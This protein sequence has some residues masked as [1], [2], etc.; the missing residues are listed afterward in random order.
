MSTK[1]T[2]TKTAAITSLTDL[3]VSP[4]NDLRKDPLVKSRAPSPIGQESSLQ[5]Y[6][7]TPI[8]QWFVSR[9]GVIGWQPYGEMFVL[10]SD[11][12]EH[13]AGNE[14]YLKGLQ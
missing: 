6:D 4:R 9:P 5:Q 7:G 10:V 11:T 3:N 8:L 12:E 13:T 1:K 14:A 2:V